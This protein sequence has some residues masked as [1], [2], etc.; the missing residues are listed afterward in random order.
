MV[1]TITLAPGVQLAAVAISAAA[2]VVVAGLEAA[3]P[4]EASS[5]P[6]S[7]S[8]PA[9]GGRELVAGATPMEQMSLL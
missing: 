6:G 3:Q 4:P 8:E 2:D 9:R 7:V 1:P 5:A